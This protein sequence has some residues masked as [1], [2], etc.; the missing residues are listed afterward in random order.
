MDSLLASFEF[1][2]LTHPGQDD[3]SSK[4]NV[5]AAGN[6]LIVTAD[7]EDSIVRDWVWERDWQILMG[8]LETDLYF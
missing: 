1:K 6:N 4:M 8:L 5:T 3:T 2:N 7:E